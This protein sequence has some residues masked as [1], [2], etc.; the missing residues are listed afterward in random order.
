MPDTTN[1]SQ[2]HTI[3]LAPQSLYP[4]IPLR[5]PP[6]IHGTPYVSLFGTIIDEQVQVYGEYLFQRKI[7]LL[8]MFII[9]STI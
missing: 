3:L 4:F 7:Y 2:L 8:E 6:V 1:T 5:P 9:T